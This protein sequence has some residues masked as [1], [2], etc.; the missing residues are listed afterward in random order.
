MGQK[1]THTIGDTV[2]IYTKNICYFCMLLFNNGYLT[3]MFQSVAA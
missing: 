3:P 1:L 2:D